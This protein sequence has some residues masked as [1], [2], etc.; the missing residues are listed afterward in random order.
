MRFRTIAAV[1]LL[2]SFAGPAAAF[3]QG[4]PANTPTA[5]DKALAETL[6]REAKK[7]MGDGKVAEACPKFAESHRLDST[8]GSLLNLAVCHEEDG[9]TAS[10]WAEFT[11]A[12][13]RALAA[14]NKERA[15]F[16]KER[17]AALE[18]KL[19][20]VALDVT[21]KAPGMKVTLGE[22]EVGEATF[23]TAMPFDPGPLA[24]KVEAPGKK[25]YVETIQ[26]EPGPSEKRVQVP[27]LETAP[28]VKPEEEA[29][30]KGGLGGQRIG[31]L[32]AGGLGLV[33]IGVGAAFGV[34]A[35]EGA[36]ALEGRCSGATCKT[37]ADVEENDEALL[38]A[39]IS[40]AGFVVGGVGL[41][42][43]AI[44]WFTAP[45]RG[46]K[47]PATGF[48]HVLPSVSPTGAGFVM[49]GAF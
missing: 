30:T 41:A 2:S 24:L 26:V 46:Q 49:G 29:T 36:A 10:A 32:A 6:F 27:A 33:G 35:L 9:K 31:A 42:A 8:L 22:R 38:R 48:V 17:A 28:P 25:P 12:V 4:N 39:H 23:G 11:E 15:A 1:L 16:A 18:K 7:L 44:L 47:P 13:S 40:T 21:V 19:S 34:M 5:A 14:K 20:R 45:K 3:G 37:T 43:A